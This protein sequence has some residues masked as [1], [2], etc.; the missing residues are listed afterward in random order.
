M[1]LYQ[2]QFSY[3]AEAWAKL[4][5]N[6]E[7]RSAEVG[8]LLESLGGRLLS[9]YYYIGGEY[10]GVLILEA[11]DKEAALAATISAF[12]AGG[13]KALN[14]TELVSVEEGMEA[15]RRAGEQAFRAPGE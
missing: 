4:A 9:F 13:A 10:D 1:S 7:D 12:A 14:T 6:P 11:P 8:A 15:M 5:R 2:V 3:T